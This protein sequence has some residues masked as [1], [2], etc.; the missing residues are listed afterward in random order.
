M[1]DIYD[2][3]PVP[4]SVN[5]PESQPLHLTRFDKMFLCIELG[6]ILLLS[7][8]SWLVDGTVGFFI[9]LGGGLVVLESWHTSLMFLQRHEYEDRQTRLLIHLA[10]LVP[11]LMVLGSAALAMLGLFWLSDYLFY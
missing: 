11:W 4:V 3:T 10:A 1:R 5:L 9:G 6:L 8:L 7:F 2:A